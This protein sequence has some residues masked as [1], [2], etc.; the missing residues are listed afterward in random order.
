MGSN[1][2]K[3][4]HVNQT[5]MILKT[6]LPDTQRKHWFYF[7]TIGIVFFATGAAGLIY[8]VAWQRYLLNL[9]GAT[10]YSI[11]TVLAAFMGGLALGSLVFGRLADRLRSPLRFYGILEITVG[12]TALLVPLMVKRLD[13]IFLAV[14]RN[15]GSNFFVYSLLRF[16]LIALILLVPTTM[17]GGTLPLLSKFVAPQG[18]RSGA[19]IGALYALN[20]LGAVAGTVTCGFFLIR[21]WGVSRTVEIAATINFLAG[22]IAIVLSKYTSTL[23]PRDEQ[24]EA[25][26]GNLS[27]AEEEI[28]SACSRRKIIYA[29][30]L[31][32]GFAAL[33]LEVVW[34]R[35][36]VFTFELLK[37]TTYSF[38]A[39]LAVFLIGIAAGSTAS[40]PLVEKDRSPWRTFA[41]LQILI[42]FASAVSFFVLFG[43]CYTLGASWVELV[44]VETGAVRWL[45][46]L[47]LVFLRSFVVVFPPTFLMGFAF[48][49]AVRCI[50]QLSP[51]SDI[52]ARVGRLYA[53]NTVGAILG[54]FLTGFF[55]LPTLGIAHTIWV[56]GAIQACVGILLLQKDFSSPQ[57]KRLVWSLL[58]IAALVVTFARIPRPTVFHPLEPLEK[59]LFYKEGPLATVAVTENSL[60]Y[61]TIFVDN[62]GVA[63]TEP[64]LLT[65]QKSLAHVPMLLL[66]SPKSA[67]TVGFGSG[68]ASYSYTLHPELHRIDCIEITETVVEAAPTL[69]DSNHD[70][71]MYAPEYRRRMGQEPKGF[72]L[73]N[74]GGKSGWWKI[75]SRYQIILDDVRS[76]LHFTDAHYDIIATDCTDL[77]YK[78]NANLYD[79]E[80]F[81]LCRQKV[82]DNG[83]VVV[84]MP[85]AGL[86]DEA[87]RVALRTFYRVFPNM[88]V[89]YMNNEP[90]HY[91]LLIGTKA[92][93]RINV[94]R[95]QEKLS[96]PAVQR[97]LAELN[98]DSVEK[99][100][101]CFVCGREA[102]ADFLRGEILNTEDFPYLEFE[103]PRF[104]YGDAPILMN[105]D[106]LYRVQEHPKK[107]LDL[108][109]CDQATLERL[110]R[111]YAAVP[112]IIEGH[113]HYRRLHV[114]EAAR[115]WLKALEINPED[116]SVKALLSFEEL[117]R[118]VVG[119]PE[120]LWAKVTL[121]DVMLIQGRESEAATAFHDTIRKIEERPDLPQAEVFYR[122]ASQRL[123]ELYQRR[124]KKEESER[125]RKKAVAGLAFIKEDK[126]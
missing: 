94:K 121:G 4:Q 8:Q 13:P 115:A 79:L 51:P 41:I 111:Y 25:P 90:T 58:G 106:S 114:A 87:F 110:E 92:P 6:S 21:W 53:T 64:M 27:V 44:N 125:Y 83:M 19:R 16:V 102:L 63:G 47:F 69:T 93:L 43:L 26:F 36:L 66:D 11:S 5:D 77:R 3:M 122:H 95:M 29:A 38:T 104:G 12:F 96:V 76:Y 46:T 52:G 23:E 119:Q 78:S 49:Y 62:V 22:V 35:A 116:K 31:V 17:M 60:R 91:I 1:R 10:I 32:S 65:D 105:L 20:T 108:A 39:M 75:D 70:V 67:L 56:M 118:K 80:Y 24:I 57:A 89:F 34:S 88:E 113:K 68:G 101:S 86:S 59:L 45:Q 54:S 126:Q 28:T 50:M 14:Y 55:L 40:A 42:G 97:D 15:W 71:V 84:W 123:A 30:Y 33:S 98:L 109:H 81:T 100:L 7:V 117:R 37:N 2:R 124:G 74:D 9:F 61:R 18:R 107:L 112:Y 99:I 72:P 120:N 82:T 85:L 48:P 103:S 73:W